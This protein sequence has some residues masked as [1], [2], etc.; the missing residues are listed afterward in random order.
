[1]F[2]LDVS[3]SFRNQSH[4]SQA[5]QDVHRRNLSSRFMTSPSGNTVAVNPPGRTMI[6]LSLTGFSDW[7]LF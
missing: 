1:M 4:T 2:H 5:S 3:R 6:L 7:F